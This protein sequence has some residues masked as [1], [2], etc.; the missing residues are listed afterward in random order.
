MSNFMGPM[1]P[2]PAAQ[3]QPQALD[4]KTDPN[5][6]QRFR[7]FMRERVGSGPAQAPAPMMQAP[8]QMPP[9]LPEVDI[10]NTQGYA[11]GGLVGG[12]ENLGAMSKKMIDNLNNVVYGGASGAGVNYS[13]SGMS[14]APQ[15]A[16]GGGLFQFDPM[17]DQNTHSALTAQYGPLPPS[18]AQPMLQPMLQFGADGFASNIQKEMSPDSPYFNVPDRSQVQPLVGFNENNP[19]QMQ[20][21]GSSNANNQN[22]MLSQGVLGIPDV[23][24]L[25]QG[26]N[27]RSIFGFEDGG[28]VPPRETNI[29]GQYHELSYITPDEADI[30]E[31]LGGTGEAGPMGIP[32]Y[33]EDDG[34]Q[35]GSSGA[36]HGGGSDSDDVGGGPG[37]G[38]GS[39]DSDNAADD[40]MGDVGVM[41]GPSSPSNDDDLSD[42]TEVAQDQQEMGFDIFDTV[43]DFN[44]QQQE[45]AKDR[46]IR[47]AFVT[48]RF[49]NPIGARSGYVTQGS[50][51]DATKAAGYQALGL[52]DPNSDLASADVEASY[53]VPTS[54]A[55]VTGV[56]TDPLSSSKNGLLGLSAQD[57]LA[58]ENFSYAPP[59]QTNVSLSR[60]PSSPIGLQ[61]IQAIDELSFGP[62]AQS[63]SFNDPQY[64]NISQTTDFDLMGSPTSRTTTS[65]LADFSKTETF[66]SPMS[67]A[68][69]TS[70]NVV[71]NFS[72]T[73]ADQLAD[74]YGIDLDALNAAVDDPNAAMG[75]RGPTATDAKAG[76]GYDPVTDMP[77]G[78]EFATNPQ[79]GAQI[80]TNL[81]GLTREQA[82]NQPFSMDIAQ[83]MGSNP[84]GYEID[85]LTGNPIGQVGTAPFGIL[86]G[87]STLA[88]DLLMG[89]PETTQDLIE[90]GAYTGMTGQNNDDD[91]FGGDD[92]AALSN[93]L[94]PPEE[95]EV[96][97]STTL[98]QM[99]GIAASSAPTD[100]GPVLVP[101]T[102]TSAP[103]SGQMPVGFGTPQTG[104]IN[105]YSLAEMQRYQQMLA[106]LGQS[107]SPVGLANGGS[108]LDAAA[109]KFLESLT[110]A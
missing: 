91:I 9:I 18:A 19:Y 16:L 24:P 107:K 30:L 99:L 108:V 40:D 70:S 54:I 59:A 75:A 36:G 63:V 29:R 93:V 76:I 64:G 65:D 11:A 83:F 45:Q 60:N 26:T 101:S 28:S 85:T 20:P 58:I 95:E 66:S 72:P 14:S 21:L 102:R 61:D 32:S 67:S 73:P 44:Q 87:L 2:P 97:A 12:L 1:A 39:D 27:M 68:S 4:F 110:A 80:T 90:R 74:V 103:F 33:A 106:R 10:F 56:P 79:T 77:Y 23:T 52:P 88:Q 84:Y 109:G 34:D 7:Q 92:D 31:A 104:Q 71:D 89:N 38:D 81:A 17:Q 105:P 62:P 8:A 98:N 57:L 86:G 55:A 51:S 37:G 41:D 3:P 82:K 6:R 42:S 96:P 25:G 48:D 50:A 53:G 49:G 43:D 69:A 35:D 47:D 100:P 5:Q 15:N 13:D 46:A 94:L 78:L 22:L